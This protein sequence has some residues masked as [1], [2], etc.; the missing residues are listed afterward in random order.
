MTQVSTQF[1]GVSVLVTG[2]CG[3]IGSHLVAALNAAGARVTVLDNLRNGTRSNLAGLS[4]NVLVVDADVRDPV[5]VRAAIVAE[6]PRYVFHL[7]ANASV[8]ASV[9]DPAYDF[10]T[11]TAGTFVLLD[12]LRGA[13]EVEKVVIASSGAVYGEPA[14]LPIREGDST[15]PISPYGASKL[16]AEV[17]GQTMSRVYRLPVV[18]ARL[19]NCYGPRM[20][21]FVLLDL[22]RKLQQSPTRLELLGS[23]K[24][25]RDFTY[26]DD[27]VA[28]LLTLATKGLLGE[29]YNVSSGVSWSVRELADQVIAAVGLTGRTEVT[30]TGSSWAGDAQQWEVVIEKLVTLGYQPSV[31]LSDGVMRTLAWYES[32]HGLVAPK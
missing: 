18:V 24:Q 21:R 26:V 5:A 3:F 9:D 19:F 6:P 22:F 10:E 29:V 4:Y 28:G 15:I 23:G 30:T 20:P 27:T 7:A 32:V 2:G 12:A 14:R 25:V 31:A 13:A 1:Q 8:P 16:A 17:V 11:N